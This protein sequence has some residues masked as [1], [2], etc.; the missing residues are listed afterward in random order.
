MKKIY[1]TITILFAANTFATN[2]WVDGLT[3]QGWFVSAYVN[4]TNLIVK[5]PTSHLKLMAYYDRWDPII[6]STDYSPKNDE[7]F[8]ITTNKITKLADGYVEVSYRFTPVVFTNKMV[9]FRINHTWLKDYTVREFE[10]RYSTNVFYVA[11]SDTPVEVGEEDVERE[12]LK[13]D[14]D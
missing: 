11:L 7:E 3:N 9:G 1:I 5:Y 13:E 12:L 2:D 6:K 4:S 8:I 10:Q 14:D